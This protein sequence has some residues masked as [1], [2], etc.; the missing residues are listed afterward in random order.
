MRPGYIKFCPP[1]PCIREC[2]VLPWLTKHT[3][4]PHRDSGLAEPFT[5]ALSFFFFVLFWLEQELLVSV[6]LRG[7]HGPTYYQTEP[8]RTTTLLWLGTSFLVGM[9]WHFWAPQLCSL[10]T[11]KVAE[12]ELLMILSLSQTPA[13]AVERTICTHTSGACQR[14]SPGRRGGSKEGYFVH[15][16]KF[17]GKTCQRW[18][19]SGWSLTFSACYGY[20]VVNC[21]I[22]DFF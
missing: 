17:W 9:T 10:V 16:E 5:R 21:V 22:V 13:Q 14:S 8:F 7:P 1:L 19:A 20:G 18:F 12:S 11:A 6:A 4:G 2:S 15:F 3:S